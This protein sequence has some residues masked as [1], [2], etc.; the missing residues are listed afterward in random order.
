[1]LFYTKTHSFFSCFD[2]SVIRVSTLIT[3]GLWFDLWLCPNQRHTKTVPVPCMGFSSKRTNYWLLYPCAMDSIRG[4]VLRVIDSCKNLFLH[5]IRSVYKLTNHPLCMY[6]FSEL[7]MTWDYL[8]AV[9]ERCGSINEHLSAFS[10]CVR[11][12]CASHSGHDVPWI[13]V[14]T[15]KNASLFDVL[16]FSLFKFCCRRLAA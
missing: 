12:W 10:C 9:Q 5:Y 1:M 7:S 4:D 14:P 13:P 11:S 3:G 6:V 2:S 8:Q 15:G 16:I